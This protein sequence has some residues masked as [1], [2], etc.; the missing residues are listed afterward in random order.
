MIQAILVINNYGNPRLMRF[1]EV[2]DTSMQQ[3][4]LNE[5]FKMVSKRQSYMCNFIEGT[6][7]SWGKNTKLIYR[8]YATL[9]FIFVVDDTESELGILD[10]IQTFVESLDRV[11]RN[12]CELDLILHVDRVSYLLDEVVQGGMVLETRTEEI[13]KAVQEQK[14][15]ERQENPI[16]STFQDVAES[17]IFKTK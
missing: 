5:T 16:K 8:H 17:K 13:M 10:L 2:K 1:Y 11:F 7:T 4:L 14:K 9:Y 3:K 6:G 12:V 15:I